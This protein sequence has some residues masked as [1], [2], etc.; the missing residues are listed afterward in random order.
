LCFCYVVNT[1]IRLT[2]TVLLLFAIMQHWW[3]WWSETPKRAAFSYGRSW[4]IPHTR[5]L[6]RMRGCLHEPRRDKNSELYL[7]HA[8]EFCSYALLSSRT[9]Q[10]WQHIQVTLKHQLWP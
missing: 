4:W 5:G 9:Q 7:H 1:P 10:I 2:A 8:I 3:R 6:S